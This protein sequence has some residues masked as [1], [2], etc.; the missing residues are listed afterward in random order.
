LKIVHRVEVSA[1]VVKA[2]EVLGEVVDWPAWTPTMS[3]VRPL[4][5]PSLK[6][7]SRFEITQP[8]MP[9]L[10]WRMTELTIGEAFTWVADAPGLTTT[11]LHRLEPIA[12]DRCA[13]TLDFNHGGA[14]GWLASLLTGHR[15][16]RMVHAE[17]TAFARRLSS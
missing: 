3:Q 17:A 5:G 8:R 10:T 6:L 7:G 2:W 13:C 11:A 9:R 12:P 1:S 14:L 4:D 15:T 16:D